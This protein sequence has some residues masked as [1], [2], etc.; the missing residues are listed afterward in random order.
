MA[1]AFINMYR[2]LAVLPKP[3]RSPELNFVKQSAEDFD[4]PEEQDYQEQCR[5]EKNIIVSIDPYEDD[6]LVLCK[7]AKYDD[8]KTLVS[9]HDEEAKYQV[10]SQHYHAFGDASN[11][12]YGTCVYVTTHYLGGTPTTIFFNC[13][14]F[15][16]GRVAPRQKISTPG[17]ELCA[18]LLNSEVME[19]IAK[20]YDLSTNPD[21]ITY[22]SDSVV[23]L[24]WICS[25][26]P[27]KVFVQ[28]RVKKI[29]SKMKKQQWNYCPGIL[30]PA[31]VVSRGKV[32]IEELLQCD[33]SWYGPQFIYHTSKFWP[34]NIFKSR[35]PDEALEEMMEAND[36]RSFLKYN[37]K[38][39][40]FARLSPEKLA[41]LTK[42]MK[43]LMVFSSHTKNLN[44]HGEDLRR[45][46]MA[47]ED[48]QRRLT[49]MKSSRKVKKEDV[50][51]SKSTLL[52]VQAILHH[53]TIPSVGNSSKESLEG[54]WQWF[55]DSFMPT[56]RKFDKLH[57]DEVEIIKKD[58]RVLCT[59]SR[60]H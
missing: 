59:L 25:D 50:F 39:D 33:L 36:R 8:K 56:L 31:G 51:Y 12:G 44:A 29:L 57:K 4:L 54:F 28:N 20:V 55:W 24:Y 35:P 5:R 42:F 45:N 32:S 9:L 16:K 22:W 43:F 17:L 11:L 26:K 1:K 21:N 52:E 47:K 41:S 7:E 30:N 3:N 13:P 60:I 15:H 23:A 40:G 6:G 14:V 48:I 58:Q 19:K 2:G 46:K 10:L 27:M 18:A 37:L 53:K 49:I 34:A 38:S